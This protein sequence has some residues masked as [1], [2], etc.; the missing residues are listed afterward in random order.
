MT[1]TPVCHLQLTLQLLKKLIAINDTEIPTL[2][3]I[4]TQLSVCGLTFDVQLCCVQRLPCPIVLGMDFICKAQLVLDFNSGSYWCK[5]HDDH[6]IQFP[7]H[8]ISPRLMNCDK[9]KLNDDDMPTRPASQLDCPIL[10]GDEQEQLHTLLNEFGDVMSEEPGRTNVTQHHIDVGNSPPQR[11]P[12][13][14][15]SNERKMP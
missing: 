2:G 8:G 1:R 14:R 4:C 13:Y 6:Q 3:S 5:T 9:T 15:L 7:L 12:P 11:S 10:I